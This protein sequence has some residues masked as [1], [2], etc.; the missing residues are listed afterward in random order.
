MGITT[1][2]AVNRAL[3][4]AYNVT[5]S[6]YRRVT[7]FDDYRLAHPE[8]FNEL[9][10]L[11]VESRLRMVL[12]LL[13][14]VEQPV[15]GPTRKSAAN[16]AAGDDGDTAAV[17]IAASEVRSCVEAIVA[18]LEKIHVELQAH[19]TRFLSTLRSPN[20]SKNLASLTLKMSVMDRRVDML[21]KARAFE[22][23]APVGRASADVGR[24][25]SNCNDGHGA[26]STTPS[27][28]SAALLASL[29]SPTPAT[30]TS[31]TARQ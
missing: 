15:G 9:E 29:S 11:D 3:D 28:P 24:A 12:A 6:T 23:S 22:A 1:G 8:I 17:R 2:R 25:G 10:Q 18:E 19:R 26:A 7:N 21:V 14:S 27:E 30:T 13:A 4:T 20:V 31:D 16:A 5:S